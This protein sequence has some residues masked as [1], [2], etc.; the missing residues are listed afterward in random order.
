MAAPAVVGWEI[1]EQPVVVHSI[2]GRVRLRFPRRQVGE[3]PILAQRLLAH[4]A[5]S[6][7]RWSPSA[8]SLTV[9]FL[10]AMTLRDLLLT[11]PPSA[12]C[13]A[14]KLETTRRLDWGRIAAACLLASLPIGVFAS[15]ALA[16]A[17]ELAG[18]ARNRR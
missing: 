16:V 18:Q 3:A 17:T 4:P 8:R 11:A 15:V 7:L 6:S 13:P 10:P 1:L 5:V 2:P 9:Q 12:E 14:A